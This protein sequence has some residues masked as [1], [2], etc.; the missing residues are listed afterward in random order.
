MRKGKSSKTAERLGQAIYN[1]DIILE[2]RC[3]NLNHTYI[4]RQYLKR[5]KLINDGLHVN[6]E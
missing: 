6:S 3:L 2:N 1:I 5:N 4:N